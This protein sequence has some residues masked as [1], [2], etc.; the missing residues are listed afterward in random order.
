METQLNKIKEVILNN[1]DGFTIGICK[2]HNWVYCGDKNERYT[3]VK[4]YYKIFVCPDCREKK[5]ILIGKIE[6]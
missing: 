1:K 6:D 4:Y 3:Y 5:E 2:K